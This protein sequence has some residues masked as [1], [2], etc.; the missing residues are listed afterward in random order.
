MTHLLLG[1]GDKTWSRANERC[2]ISLTDP[3]QYHTPC[4]EEN[5]EAH[6]K[7]EEGGEGGHCAIGGVGPGL[8]Y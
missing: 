1:G 3:Q 8:A 7:G 5:S 2:H 4:Q 6:A